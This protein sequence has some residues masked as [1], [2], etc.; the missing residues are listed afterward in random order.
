[1]TEPLVKAV[2]VPV[3]QLCSALLPLSVLNNESAPEENGNV[4]D[5][6]CNH[7]QEDSNQTRTGTGPG[8][9]QTRIDGTE[10][11]QA[12]HRNGDRMSDGETDGHMRAPS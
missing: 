4:P 10:S 8:R 2:M 11:D 7:T 1:M 6:E 5:E 9:S 3:G 12:P